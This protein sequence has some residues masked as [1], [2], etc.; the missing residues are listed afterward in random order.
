MLCSGLLETRLT[1]R[2]HGTTVHLQLRPVLVAMVMC[3]GDGDGDGD[4]MSP[5]RMLLQAQQ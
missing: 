4:G 1:T 3:G 5:T 2:N